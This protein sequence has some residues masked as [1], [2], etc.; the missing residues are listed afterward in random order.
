MILLQ[1]SIK[2]RFLECA[3]AMKN[4]KIKVSL[5]S[6]VFSLALLMNGCYYVSSHDTYGYTQTTVPKTSANYRTGG[7]TVIPSP[8]VVTHYENYH[9]PGG[10]FYKKQR[11]FDYTKDC[12]NK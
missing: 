2:E 11:N 8:L 10:I 4:K 5:Q 7:T 6:F 12:Q 1:E 3:Y 9:H